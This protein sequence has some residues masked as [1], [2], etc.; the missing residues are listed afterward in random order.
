MTTSSVDSKGAATRALILETAMRLFQERGYGKTTMR[1][2][3][4][5]AGVSVGNAYYYFASKEQLIQGFYDRL[6]AD[7]LVAA[8]L[9]LV[10][11]TDLARRLGVVL[12]TWLDV[13]EPYHQFAA[14]FFVTAADPASPLSPF[15]SDSKE[16]RD[17]SIEIQVEAVYGASTKIDPK[18]R[19]T[20]PELAWL[21]MMGLVLY[22][23]HD[24]SAGRAK[25]Y[26][27][28]D[29][30]VPIAGKVVKLSRYP[31]AKAM[32][33]EVADICLEH[34]ISPRIPKPPV[35]PDT[36]AK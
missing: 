33:R 11:E 3:A 26:K 19:E 1:A 28:V 7:H 5:A 25:S 29:Q 24:T 21:G 20:L 18:L 31:V 22:W 30:C 14:Q 9:A 32:I 4:E 36:S 8:R 35:R 23:I 6:Q 16:A 27:L 34:G 10:G 12:K 15:S 17:A 13:A 2:I